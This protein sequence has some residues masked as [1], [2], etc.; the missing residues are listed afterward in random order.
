MAKI[1]RGTTFFTGLA[2]FRAGT[3]QVGDNR[4][5]S[6]A[7]LV[8]MEEV[9]FVEDGAGTYTAEVEIPVGATVLDVQ[10]DNDALWTAGTSA[11]VNVGDAEDADGYIT[12]VNVKTTPAVNGADGAG[13]IS[14]FN[15]DAG[16]GAYGGL[17]KKYPLGGTV[18]FV[19]VSSGAGTAGRS[20]GRVIYAAPT[21]LTTAVKA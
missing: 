18:S 13:G 9:A 15:E 10:W 5:N 4:I 11:A 21:S 8:V 12:N 19:V 3:L 7:G 14:S 17:T 6:P 2:K 20:K 16:A 1:F